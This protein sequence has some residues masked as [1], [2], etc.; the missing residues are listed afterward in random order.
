MYLVYSCILVS[1]ILMIPYFIILIV[2]KVQEKELPKEA[3]AA[4]GKEGDGK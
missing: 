3:A 4:E 2:K 1:G